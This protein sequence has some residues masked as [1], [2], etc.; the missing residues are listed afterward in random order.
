MFYFLKYGF[1]ITKNVKEVWSINPFTLIKKDLKC[2]GEQSV[3]ASFQLFNSVK[4]FLCVVYRHTQS[5]TKK[6][7]FRHSDVPFLSGSLE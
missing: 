1:N 3:K 2:G 7:S 5:K 4:I 6:Y